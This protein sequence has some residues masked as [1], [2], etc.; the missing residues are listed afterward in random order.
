MA[1]DKFKIPVAGGLDQA[2]RRLKEIRKKDPSPEL[3]KIIEDSTR[4]RPA[5]TPEDNNDTGIAARPRRPK[6]LDL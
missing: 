5:E 6:D 3:V 1:K 4:E 2:R